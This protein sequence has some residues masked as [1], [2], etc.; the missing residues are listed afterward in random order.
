MAEHQHG[1]MNIR[2]QEKTYENFIKMTVR[3][4]IGILFIV[5]ILAIFGA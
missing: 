3:S 4:V 2:V 5:V 1:S